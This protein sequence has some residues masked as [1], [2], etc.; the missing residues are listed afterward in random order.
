[1]AV[2]SSDL[3]WFDGGTMED[4]AT[5]KEEVLELA[6]KRVAERCGRSGQLIIYPFVYMFGAML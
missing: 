6:S 2:I 1:M 4:A 3:A 5:K